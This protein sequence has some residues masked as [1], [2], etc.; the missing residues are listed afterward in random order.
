VKLF[1]DM[2]SSK[3]EKINLKK[4][5]MGL[6]DQMIA[7]LSANR[8]VITHPGTKGDASELQ[9]I[10]MLN[11][12]LPQRYRVDKAFVVD[13]NGTISQQ[14]DIVV[15]DRH[16]SPFLFHQDGAIFV[17]AESVYGMFEVKQDLNKDAIEYT[18]QKAESVRI[19]KRTSVPIVHAGGKYKPK[20]PCEI[21]AGLLTLGCEWE[22][23]I[24]SKL[25]NIC[26]NLEGRQQ[27]DLGCSLQFGAFDARYEETFKIETSGKEDS[28]IFFFLRFLRRLQ[29][30]G[31]I[32]A[33]DIAEYERALQGEG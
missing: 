25:S 33:M 4:V 13:C 7:T 5:F 19:L 15:Y 12:Y 8:E 14:I 18:G 28:L 22:Q 16:Y 1:G 32:P 9:W 30:L 3:T 24:D 26:P 23:D 6:Q 27:I 21:I 31:T 17:P 20:T 10:K 2:M 11:L 29:A